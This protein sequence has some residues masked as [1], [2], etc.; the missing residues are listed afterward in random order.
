MRERRGFTL[1]ELL[2]VVAVIAVLIGVLLPALGGARVSAQR[3]M[4]TANLRSIETA[5]WSYVVENDGWMLGTSHGSSWAAVLRE[6][7]GAILLRSALDTS[8]HFADGGTPIDGRYRE[9]SYSINH[10]LTPDYQ[11]GVRRV[12]QV[13]RHDATVHFV[14]AAFEGPGAVADHVHPYLWW[15]PIGAAIPGK[16]AT[17]IQTNAHGGGVG[18]WESAS[19]YGFLDGHAATLSFGAVYEG[20]ERN[21][22]DPRASNY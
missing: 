17:E 18:T 15:S 22:F 6:Y 16:A 19:G 14:I 10:F 9:T 3:V 13:R 8:P 5:H 11:E 21:R 12:D 7:D 1:I 20:R 4:C 2:V